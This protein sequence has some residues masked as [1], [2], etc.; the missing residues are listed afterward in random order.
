MLG[1]SFARW[2]DKVGALKT[3]TARAHSLAQRMIRAKLGL[4]LLSWCESVAGAKCV[5]HV[6][7]RVVRRWTQ[8]MRAAAFELWQSRA[9]KARQMTVRASRL[10][11][12]SLT[13]VSA[14]CLDAWNSHTAETTRKRALA[15]KRLLCSTRHM[16]LRALAQWTVS[17][18]EAQMVR[19]DKER[20]QMVRSSA[21]LHETVGRLQSENGLQQRHARCWAC[22]RHSSAAAQHSF[23]VRTALHGSV[24]SASRQASRRKKKILEL[25]LNVN[26]NEQT[27]HDPSWASWAVPPGYSTTPQDPIPSIS[28]HRRQRSELEF[29]MA[30]V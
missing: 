24:L 18:H 1:A 2:R 9:E 21:A 28:H 15:G 3:T 10:M 13:R 19:R 8:R 27:T 11:A 22:S 4:A 29:G 30:Y 14:K 17:V 16:A 25:T 23:D 20:G 7:G 5:K 12:C 6:T 26:T